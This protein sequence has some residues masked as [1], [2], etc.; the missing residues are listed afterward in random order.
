MYIPDGRGKRPVIIMPI[1]V[2][3]SC[4]MK[5]ILSLASEISVKTQISP[6]SDGCKRFLHRLISLRSINE[7]ITNDFPPEDCM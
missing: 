2:L 5:V 3:L 7:E 1:M 6:I 4:T